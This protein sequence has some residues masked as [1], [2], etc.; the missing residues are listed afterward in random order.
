MSYRVGLIELVEMRGGVAD[1][2]D[3]RLDGVLQ[4]ESGNKIFDNIETPSGQDNVLSSYSQGLQFIPPLALQAG[5]SV[6]HT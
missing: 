1:L 3:V 2:V 5:L 6:V 4:V